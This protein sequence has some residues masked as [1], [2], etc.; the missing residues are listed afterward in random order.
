MKRTLIIATMC[1]S[2]IGC[3]GAADKALDLLGSLL[4]GFATAF[5]SNLG[6]GD[7]S[8]HRL[9]DNTSD[10]FDDGIFIYNNREHYLGPYEE[11]ESEN[12]DTCAE[13]LGG[14]IP[15]TIT[16]SEINDAQLVVAL[17]DNSQTFTSAEQ[18]K[19]DM[20]IYELESFEHGCIVALASRFIAADEQ[21]DMLVLYC[22]KTGQAEKTCN[23]L[24]VKDNE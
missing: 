14:T 10:Q 17:D 9:P 5:L 4:G 18:D 16:I 13:M 21:E 12:P 7:S 19:L 3:G 15:S 2:L 23:M 24:F 20:H 1:I 6:G 8:E 11:D 22:E